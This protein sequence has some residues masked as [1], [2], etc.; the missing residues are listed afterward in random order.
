MIY[1]L[2]CNRFPSSALSHFPT[3]LHMETYSQVK[4]HLMTPLK[5]KI[6]VCSIHWERNKLGWK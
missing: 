2:E 5:W 3:V 6:F 1:E 4:S